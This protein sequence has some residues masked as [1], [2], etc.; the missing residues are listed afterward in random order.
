MFRSFM[1]WKKNV[2][3][4]TLALVYHRLPINY[5]KMQIIKNSKSLQS[6][7][8]FTVCLRWC[9]KR[10]SWARQ[11]SDRHFC[12]SGRIADSARRRKKQYS[13]SRALVL[14]RRTKLLISSVRS[15]R[16]EK[17]QNP[18]LFRI[19][20]QSFVCTLTEKPLKEDNQCVW[21]IWSIWK[22]MILIEVP[23]NGSKTID[24]VSKTIAVIVSLCHPRTI[25][26][27]STI[28]VEKINGFWPSSSEPECFVKELGSSWFPGSFEQKFKEVSMFYVQFCVRF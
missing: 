16:R 7:V 12:F 20:I 11:L 24:R 1:N 25:S 21:W 26:L 13:A 8:N 3:R 4:Q 15:A 19:N 2:N 28:S 23:V 17:K 9:P 6:T 14:F 10:V 27:A 18:L 22:V 5:Q